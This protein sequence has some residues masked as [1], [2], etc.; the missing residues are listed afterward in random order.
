MVRNTSEGGVYSVTSVIQTLLISILS[1]PNYGDDCSIRIVTVLLGQFLKSLFMLFIHS[2]PLLT[3]QTYGPP[4]VPS[5]LDNWGFAVHWSMF[6]MAVNGEQNSV[7]LE[8]TVLT[9]YYSNT[10]EEVM[11]GRCVRYCMTIVILANRNY[12]TL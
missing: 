7:V 1:S 12:V 11:W 6:T 5:G 4:L 8:L 10:F 3:F 2:S 9:L